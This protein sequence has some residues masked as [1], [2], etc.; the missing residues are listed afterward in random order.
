MNRKSRKTMSL[1]RGVVVR[2]MKEKREEA[3]LVSDPKMEKLPNKKNLT[4]RQR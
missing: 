1:Y 4:P 2:M 3:F